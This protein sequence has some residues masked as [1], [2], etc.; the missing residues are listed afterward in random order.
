M[1]ATKT[2]LTTNMLLALCS[3]CSKLS[4]AVEPQYSDFDK[5]TIDGL[6]KRG[7]VHHTPTRGRVMPTDDGF[8]AVGNLAPVPQYIVEK[9]SAQTQVTT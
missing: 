4:K 6:I 2:K 8:L 9:R 1:T 5:R 7:L 3:M